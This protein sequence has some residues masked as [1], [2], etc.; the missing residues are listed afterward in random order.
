MGNLNFASFNDRIIEDGYNIS[1]RAN[2]NELSYITK[3]EFNT[4]KFAQKSL[5]ISSNIMKNDKISQENLSIKRPGTGISPIHYFDFI[6]KKVKINL[7]KNTLISK[8]FLK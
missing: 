2:P 1:W 3:S 7:K 6:G 5:V 4:K 8:K